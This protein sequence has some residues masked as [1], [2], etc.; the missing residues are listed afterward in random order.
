MRGSRAL[1]TIPKLESLML[2]LGFINCAWLKMLKNSNRISKAKF[3][4]IW[5]RFKNPKSVL[6]NPGPWKKRRLAVPK[7]PRLELTANALGRKNI[8]FRAGSGRQ[9][10]DNR[11]KLCADPQSPPGPQHLAYPWANCRRAKHRLGLV[12]SVRESR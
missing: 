2:P 9:H 7:V 12:A 11:H 4:L 5:V 1:V 10:S 3:S 6:L 8:P